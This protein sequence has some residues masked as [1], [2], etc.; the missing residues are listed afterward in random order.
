MRNPARALAW[1]EPAQLETNW[2]IDRSLDL[3]KTKSGALHSN[4]DNKNNNYY[5]TNYESSQFLPPL[6]DGAY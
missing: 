4:N 6:K 1:F 2:N 3:A 5:N